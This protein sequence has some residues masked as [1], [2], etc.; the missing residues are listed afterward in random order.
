VLVST[1]VGV[2]VVTVDVLLSTG[3]SVDEVLLGAEFDGTL[4]CTLLLLLGFSPHATKVNAITTAIKTKNNFFIFEI[5]FQNHKQI[6]TTKSGLYINF[7]IF[8]RIQ[9]NVVLKK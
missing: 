4:F 7:F 2:G 8:Q 6:C 9:G 3:F 1:G 5:L